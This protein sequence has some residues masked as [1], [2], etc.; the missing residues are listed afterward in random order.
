M[1]DGSASR[2]FLIPSLL[3]LLPLLVA[4]TSLWCVAVICCFLACLSQAKQCT[5]AQHLDTAAVHIAAVQDVPDTLLHSLVQAI[6][7]PAVEKA[8]VHSGAAP[9]QPAEG[10]LGP[11]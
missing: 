4:T 10:C 7:S 6:G 8:P 3:K 5:C 1:T 2:L 11:S 9:R